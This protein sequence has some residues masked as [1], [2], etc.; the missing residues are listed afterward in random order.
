MIVVESR[1][2]GF[3]AF[4]A[5]SPGRSSAVCWAMYCSIAHSLVAQDG[6]GQGIRSEIEDAG[7]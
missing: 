3:G 4:A 7:G 1:E 2:A 6:E 5:A